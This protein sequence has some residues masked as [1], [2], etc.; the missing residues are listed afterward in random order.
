M[1]TLE[2]VREQVEGLAAVI[3]APPEN[4]PTYGRSEQS[5]RPHVEVTADGLMHWVVCERGEEFDR[6]TT[7]RR[8]DLLYWIF[9][10]VTFSMAAKYEIQHRT[11]DEDFRKKL[12]TK[13]F[14]LLD[15]LN[16]AWT[17]RRK[18]ELGPLLLEAGLEP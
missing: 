4:L 2:T 14:E 18:D 5:G 8:D 10:S 11:P 13:Q 1:G 6:R 17:S 16:S 3:G 9:N 15:R 7:V 12:F